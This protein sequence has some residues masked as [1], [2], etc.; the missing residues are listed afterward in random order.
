MNKIELKKV[1]G[2]CYVSDYDMVISLEDNCQNTRWVLRKQGILIDKDAYR[3]DLA[4]RNGLK[5]VS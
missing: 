4:E 3:H 5:L 1:N 2:Y